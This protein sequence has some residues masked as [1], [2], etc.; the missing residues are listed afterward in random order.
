MTPYRGG[1]TLHETRI[2]HYARGMETFLSPEASL[3][4]LFAAAFVATTLLPL[5]S[6]AALLQNW[7]AVALFQAA[8]RFARY[9]L[10]SAGTLY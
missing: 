2:S 3:W 9:W 6:E 7:I 1:D 10:I 4:S 5:S 8:G